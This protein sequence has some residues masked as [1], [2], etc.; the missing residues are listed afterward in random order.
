M[1]HF[2]FSNAWCKAAS[3]GQVK[4]R[5]IKPTLEH[6]LTNSKSRWTIKRR[7]LEAG[8]LKNVCEEC[9][10]QEWLGRPL[11]ISSPTGTGSET[12]PPRNPRMLCANCHSQAETY[13]SRN[14]KVLRHDGPG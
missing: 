1:A 14:K 8:I 2:G 6:V 10:L 12:T 11:V 7:L 3:L 5:S 9:G 13:C 4:S